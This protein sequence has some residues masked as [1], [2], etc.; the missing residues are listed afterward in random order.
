[1]DGTRRGV[2][3]VMLVTT[4]QEVA[5]MEVGL[6]APSCGGR[7]RQAAEAGQVIVAEGTVDQLHMK[8][9]S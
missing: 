6:G 2:G 8:D 7:A 9:E 3:I 1:L 5:D 4:P